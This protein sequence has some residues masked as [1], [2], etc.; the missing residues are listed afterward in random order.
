MALIEETEEKGLDA[1]PFRMCIPAVRAL[2]SF[3]WTPGG[4]NMHLLILDSPIRGYCEL[5]LNLL[6]CSFR[7]LD[8]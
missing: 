5:T 1:D 3:G 7:W 2:R 4:L 8:L 6:F